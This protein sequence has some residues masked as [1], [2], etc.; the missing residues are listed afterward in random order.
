[1]GKREFF[2]LRLVHFLYQIRMTGRRCPFVGTRRAEIEVQTLSAKTGLDDQEGF[3]QRFVQ[4]D[5]ER[6]F[7]TEHIAVVS[8]PLFLSIH[9]ET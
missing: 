7:R 4:V 3:L 9:W 2:G 6:E 5:S 8:F 1:M